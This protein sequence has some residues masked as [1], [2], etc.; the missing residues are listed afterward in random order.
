MIIRG[1][2]V[3]QFDFDGLKIADYTATLDGKSSFAV[4]S[5]PPQVGHK[6]SWSKR[7][8]KYYYIMA[9][10]I[11]FIVDNK[12]FVLSGGDLCVIKK[13]DTFS[14]KNNSAEFVKMILIHT[15]NFNL[16]QEVF[17]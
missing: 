8:D 15:P 6:P 13:G 3:K 10:E 7:S 2:D 11:T 16:D 14:Y 9:G 5:V 17:E 4:L 1:N 12:E